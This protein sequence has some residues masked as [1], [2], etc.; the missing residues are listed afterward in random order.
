MTELVDV[1]AF[2]ILLYELLTGLKPVMGDTVE[3]LFYIILHEPLDS[4]Q[5]RRCRFPNSAIA[6]VPLH[7]QESGR[8]YTELHADQPGT[9]RV[10]RQ[11]D[12]ATVAM[13][14]PTAGPGASISGER[15]IT[16]PPS[17]FAMPAAAKEP[18]PARQA[19]TPPPPP[20]KKSGN[21]LLIGGLIALLVL[22]GLGFAAYRYLPHGTT[23]GGG[24]PAATWRCRREHGPGA[25]GRVSV[26]REEGK[27]D[28]ARVLYRRDRSDQ[29]RLLP[30]LPGE[31]AA[32]AA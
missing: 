8:A 23:G 25:G 31:E 11:A 29:R 3:R 4:E 26:W 27:R 7:G 9:G 14:R 32:A 24:E 12:G 17:P 20:V 2:G 28:A 21:G 30:V 15:P 13:L 22:G 6:R 18:D 1:Y 19:S 5:D 10:L 16:Q